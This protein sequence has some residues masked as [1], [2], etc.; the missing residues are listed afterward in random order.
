MQPAAQASDPAHYIRSLQERIL[1]LEKSFAG[2]VSEEHGREEH[3]DEVRAALQRDIRS[4]K[5]DMKRVEL[6]LNAVVS[7][8]TKLV[9]QFKNSAQQREYTRLKQRVDAWKG[10]Q[11]ITRKE[12]KNFRTCAHA[13][14]RNQNC[15][16]QS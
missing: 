16:C 11:Y 4:L 7:D 15:N 6:A 13:G 2:M 5:E 14:Q 10:E 3:L 8:T 1:K 12:F 9:S